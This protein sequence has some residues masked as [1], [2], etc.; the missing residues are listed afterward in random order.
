MERDA[1]I[2]TNQQTQAEFQ[3]IQE[4]A[5]AEFE[6]RVEAIEQAHQATLAQLEASSKQMIATITAERDADQAARD[7]AERERTMLSSELARVTR[8]AETNSAEAVRLTEDDHL[9]RFLLQQSIVDLSRSGHC[10]PR[11][12]AFVDF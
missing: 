11:G 3:T 10:C 9:R 7:A 5:H 1:A 4:Q 2:A 12:E 8:L 6:A